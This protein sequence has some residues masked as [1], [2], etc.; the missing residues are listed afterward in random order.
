MKKLTSYIV[1]VLFFFSASWLNA[2][3]KEY[4]LDNGLKVIIVEDHKVPL[5][6]FQVWYKVGS[7]NEPAGKTGISHLLEHMMFKGTPEYGSKE[8]SRLVKKNGGMDNAYTTRDYTAYFQTMSSDRIDISIELEADR[9]QNLLLDPQEV[10]SERDVVKE[11]RRLRYEDDPQNS[12]FEAVMAAAFQVHPYHHPIIG[13]MSDLSSINRDD[14]Y[15]YYKAYYAPDNAFVIVAGDVNPEATFQKIKTHFGDIPRGRGRSEVAS[16][17]PEQKGERRVS[18]RKEAELP[19]VLIAFRVPNFPHEDSFALDVLESILSGK[20]GRL[21]RNIIRDK[22]ISI[23]VFGEYA[24]FYVDPMLFYL[25][26]T[27]SPGV[28]I[29]EVE[30]ALY[31]EL[32]TLKENPP[33]EK[34]VQKGINQAEASFI[35]GQDSLF[36][37]ARLT[38]MFELFGGWELKDRYLEGIRSVTPQDVQAVA[39][40]Y[41]T[42]ENRTVGILVPEKRRD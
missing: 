39:K 6:T 16:V 5:A 20:S 18:L 25:G 4:T 34:E 40:K 13:W 35:F 9:M 8:F 7:R 19:Y 21:Y 37:Q 31:D 41:F 27:A 12:L 38:G 30:K 17:E 32:E 22:K 10:I 1:F 14:L 23:E 28:A 29:A 3:V 2:A 15:A 33:S 24:G 42:E 36:S 11:E 26:G